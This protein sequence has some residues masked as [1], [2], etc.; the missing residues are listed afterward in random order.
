[1]SLNVMH[2]IP[3]RDGYMVSPRF[4]RYVGLSL[5]MYG[6]YSDAERV[7]LEAFLSPGDIVVQVGANVGALTIPLARK[8]GRTGKVIAFEPQDVM[9]RALIANSA[10]T[11]QWQV[12]ALKVAIGSQNGLASL[13]EINYTTPGNFGGVSLAPEPTNVRVQLATLDTALKTI[14]RCALLHIDAEGAELDVLQGGR[15]FIDRTRPVLCVEVD[16]PEVRAG[17]GA[18]LRGNRYEGFE[19]HPPL[20]NPKNFRGLATNVFEDPS[21][22]QVVSINCIL[23]PAEKSKQLAALL[24]AGVRVWD[25]EEK[26]A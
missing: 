2:L 16:R 13:P 12:E 11:D 3:T 1:V 8:V 18:W 6:E 7:A 23:L 10:L 19:H 25:K 26:A 22:T 24:P 21:G 20:F 5:D 9:Y 14:D 15:G 4:D 17:L